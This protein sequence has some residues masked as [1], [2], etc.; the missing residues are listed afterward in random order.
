MPSLQWQRWWTSLAL[1]YWNFRHFFFPLLSISF[2]FVSWAHSDLRFREDE[3]RALTSTSIHCHCCRSFHISFEKVESLMASKTCHNLQ[4]WQLKYCHCA[5]AQIWMQ[6]YEDERW[7]GKHFRREI[8]V[9]IDCGGAKS[10]F[11]KFAYRFLSFAFPQL[12]ES[13]FNW[14]ALSQLIASKW[15]SA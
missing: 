10:L 2:C 1:I 13:V 9:V 5:L 8:R 6:K 11:S 15:K 3:W 14:V 7:H 4:I 12:K